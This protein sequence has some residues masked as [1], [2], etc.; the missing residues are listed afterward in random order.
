ME[1]SLSILIAEINFGLKNKKK[2]IFHFYTNK[3]LKFIKLLYKY[4]IILVFKVLKA[5]HLVVIYL[6]NR[7][8]NISN[9]KTLKTI[10]KSSKKQ[11]ITVYNIKSFLNKNNNK[12]LIL[13]VNNSFITHKE[14][15]NQYTG[16]ELICIF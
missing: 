1:R 14:A 6:K 11:Y 7:S 9:I 16:G 8:F 4:N 5:K 15:L 10:S 3:T 2:K 12:F 13:Y